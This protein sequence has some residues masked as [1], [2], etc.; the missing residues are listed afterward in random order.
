MM[1]AMERSAL[2]LL[3]SVALLAAAGCGGSPDPAPKGDGKKTAANDTKTTNPDPEPSKLDV[4]KPLMPAVTLSEEDAA[5]CLVKVGD[6]MPD[7]KLP[8]FEGKAK[9]VKDLFGSK[10]TIVVFWSS[11]S[12]YSEAALQ[13]LSHAATGLAEKGI[14]V[15]AIHKGDKNEGAKNAIEWKITLPQL[16]DEDGAALA[17]VSTK[18]LPRVYLLDPAGK[19]LWFEMSYDATNTNRVLNDALKFV[20]GS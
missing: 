19:I 17:K 15:V 13:D 14:K 9:S 2:T 6:A 12:P 10:G 3:I 20:L 11:T 1:R 16:A 8:D 18:R 7:I 5:T 4:P